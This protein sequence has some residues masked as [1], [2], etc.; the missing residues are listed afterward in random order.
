MIVCALEYYCNGI[1]VS[2]RYV[3]ILYTYF[4]MLDSAE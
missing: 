3:L 2:P 1:D 4:S